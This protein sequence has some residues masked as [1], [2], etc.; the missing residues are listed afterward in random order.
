MNDLYKKCLKL[1]KKHKEI[2]RY[3]IVGCMTTLVSIVS[4]NL[5]RIW[6]EDDKIYK[7]L[8]LSFKGY[9]ICTV[10]SWI[11]A[12]TFAYFTNRKYVFESKEENVVKEMSQFFA[13][14]LLSLGAEVLVMILLVAVFGLNDRISKIIVQFIVFVLNYIFSKVFVFKN[15]KD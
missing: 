5:F 10:L 2:V 14:R 1:Y 15:K 11:I 4:Y 9:L 12:V 7:I 3:L 8:G 13:A 6:L